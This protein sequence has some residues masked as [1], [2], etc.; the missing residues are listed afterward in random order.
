VIEF[1]ALVGTLHEH[2]ARFPI[3]AGAGTDRR[4]A[5]HR[6]DWTRFGL[7]IL[8]RAGAGQQDATQPIEL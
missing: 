8:C 1:P 3:V 7:S 5:R 6:S 2:G 4:R